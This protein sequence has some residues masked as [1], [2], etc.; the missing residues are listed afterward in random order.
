MKTLIVEDDFTSRV[1]MQ[2]YL[3]P[4]G[5]S[6]I[7][8][9]GKE[10]VDAYRMALFDGN[11]YD[12]ICLDI[13]MP[14]M[15]GQETLRIIRKLEE[16]RGIYSSDGVKIIMTTALDDMENIFSAYKGLCDGYLVKP[17]CRDKLVNTLELCG[18]IP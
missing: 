4:Y 15:D 5:E 8:V 3:R 2:E 17:I 14:E 16:N 7:A 1:L 9:H 13:L 10:A 18:L 12:L 6:H 11:P